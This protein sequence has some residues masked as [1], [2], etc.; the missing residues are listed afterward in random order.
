MYKAALQ[1][2]LAAVLL[3]AFCLHALAWDAAGH[4]TVAAI[5]WRQ[6]TPATRDRVIDILRHAPEDSQLSAFYM[7]YGSQSRE[8]RRLDFFMTAAT[9]PDII[10][11]KELTTRNKKYSNSNWH[12]FDT[13]WREK[14]GK[15]TILPPGNEGGHMMEK[16]AD[17]DKV[18]R[19]TA[20]AEEK[21]IAIAWLEHLIGDLH[22]PL[23]AAARVIGG[24]GD[25]GDQGGNLFSLTPKGA[26]DKL[27]LHS[28]WD[29]ILEQT[30][31][32][33]G[34]LCDADYL[35]PIVESIVTEYPYS[36]LQPRLADDKYDVWEQESVDVATHELYKGL[37]RYEMPSDSY[38]VKAA[39][40]ARE[41]MALAG[42]RLADLFNEVFGTDLT[43][44][45][46]RSNVYV[47]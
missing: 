36:K 2:I 24:Q 47:P 16:L 25:K 17:L 43:D 3:P 18:V 21:A 1:V 35:R 13:L 44:S 23:H 15:I 34:D 22:Q 5:A 39:N 4:K 9:W 26:K 45:K 11:D 12:Y 33:T 40:I 42:Y 27:N 29:G 14:D 19:S 28:F 31:P 38:K 37:K 7:S 6:M 32:N 41:R 10:K 30:Q 8:A 46:P 20:P